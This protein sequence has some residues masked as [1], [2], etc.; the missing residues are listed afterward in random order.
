[1]T[2]VCFLIEPTDRARQTLR[3][4]ATGDCAT[5]GT[6]YHDAGTRIEDVPCER[7]ERGVIA[8]HGDWPRDDP[9]WPTCCACGYAFAE[10]DSWQLHIDPLYLDVATGREYTLREA[11]PGAM[12]DACWLRAVNRFRERSPDG[13][14]LMLRLPDGYEWCIDGPSSNGPGWERSGTPPQITARP[15]ILS[16]GYHGWLDHGVLSDDLEGR[17]YA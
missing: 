4:Y 3:R 11:P 1:M 8:A 13:A 5:S 16:P 15:S 7:D 2:T 17:R 14:V 10:G 12:W 9:R 6:G